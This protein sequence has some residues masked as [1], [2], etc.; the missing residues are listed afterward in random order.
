M[1]PPEKRPAVRFDEADTTAFEAVSA[2]AV[3]RA[4]RETV[5]AMR[6]RWPALEP[7]MVDRALADAVSRQIQSVPLFNE[8][9]IHATSNT[10]TSAR[11]PSAT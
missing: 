6:A 4:A 1:Q 3:Q 11:T 9:R 2:R 10:A 8:R 7:I 5:D